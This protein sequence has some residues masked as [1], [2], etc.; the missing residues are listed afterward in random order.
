MDLKFNVTA[1]AKSDAELLDTIENRQKY[2]P[3]TI[4]ASVAELQYRNHP[5]TDEELKVITEDVEAHRQN[6]NS[7]GQR[8]GLFT[9]DYKKNIIEDP[10][11]PAF[12]SRRVVYIFAFL[13]STL[14]GSILLAININKTD[15]P[16]RMLWVL[17]FGVVYTAFEI[18]VG[19]SMHSGNSP[20]IFL[21]LIGALILESFFWNRFIGNG[22]FYRARPIWV[23]LIIGLV[24]FAFIIWAMFY[25]GQGS[26]DFKP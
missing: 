21:S 7:R 5:F 16:A 22:T 1:S 24:M 3:E 23:P 12:Y 10:D 25:N 8:S 14:F 9:N 4:E 20:G 15:K 17:L 18:I 11:A 6:A 2:L 26:I 19:E 13:F